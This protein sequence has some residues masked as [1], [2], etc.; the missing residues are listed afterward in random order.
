VLVIPR[1]EIGSLADLTPEDQVL[2][3]H[4]LLVTK[5]IAADLGLVQGYR[6]VAN[7]GEHGG[8]SV[9]HLHF[10]LLGGRAMKWPPG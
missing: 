1:K 9:P 8:Q 3:G 7:T 4:L 5:K 10:H 2:V 6:V